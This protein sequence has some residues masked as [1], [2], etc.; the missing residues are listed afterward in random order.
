MLVCYLVFPKF[1]A[2]CDR[3]RNICV[4]VIGW[5][6]FRVVVSVDDSFMIHKN[7]YKIKML[8]NQNK[9]VYRIHFGD[10]D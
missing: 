4:Y 1:L 8:A 10:L 7:G 2:L 6:S 3:I 5:I 9:M